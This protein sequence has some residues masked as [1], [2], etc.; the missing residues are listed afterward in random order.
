MGQPYWT[1]D[2]DMRSSCCWALSAGEITDGDAICSRC[3]EHATF[4]AA[5][6][7]LTY[8]GTLTFDGAMKMLFPGYNSAKKSFSILEEK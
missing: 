3:G 7:L 8:D 1:P 4:E 5:P 6:E 2:Q